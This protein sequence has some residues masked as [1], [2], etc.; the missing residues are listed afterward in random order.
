[1]DIKQ[2]DKIKQE[3]LKEF[4]KVK[5]S[6]SL[7][8]ARIKFL[9]RKSKLTKI[10]R[11]IRDLPKKDRAATGAKANELKEFIEKEFESLK[12]K[13]ESEKLIKEAKDIDVTIPGTKDY[14]GH[15]NPDTLIRW[16]IEETFQK[17][18]FELWEPFGVD[19]DYHNFESLNIPEGHP[20]RDIWDTI[21][22]EN[23]F[24]PITH[25]SAMQNRILK[26]SKPPIRAVVIG[27]CFR[28]E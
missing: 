22:T 15:L 10:L 24:I 1:V 7:E 14:I 13:I 5:E 21:W 2:I 16:E 18:G 25:T 19:D 6:K 17:M 23:G 26:N 20:A 3:A 28:K 8:Q 27:P 12:S 11:S 4:G 9:G